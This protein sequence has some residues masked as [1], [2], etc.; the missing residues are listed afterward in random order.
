[1]GNIYLDS[2]AIWFEK[3]STNFKYQ[4]DVGKPLKKYIDVFM[5]LFLGDFTF[6]M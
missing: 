4:H 1:M 3:S 5:N 2:H 6:V